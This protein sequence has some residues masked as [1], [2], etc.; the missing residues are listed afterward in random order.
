MSKRA[1]LLLLLALSVGVASCVRCCDDTAKSAHPPKEVRLREAPPKEAPP[2]E[3]P[4]EEIP[5]DKVPAWLKAVGD[6]GQAKGVPSKTPS[7]GLAEQLARQ[8]TLEAGQLLAGSEKERSKNLRADLKL[9]WQTTPLRAEA[10]DKK[11][12][13]ASTFAAR[14]AASRVFNSVQLTGL[15]VEQ[16]IARLGDPK[17][18]SNSAYNC[19][20]WPATDAALIYRF[21]TGSSGWQF[22]I[23]VDSQRKVVKVRRRWIH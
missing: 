6:K 10:S 22:D 9:M 8:A 1:A 2:K 21:D 16:V 14:D 3:A 7:A 12:P 4:P 23:L 15:T 19:P 11:R 13:F 20:F 18:R 17:R 5:A